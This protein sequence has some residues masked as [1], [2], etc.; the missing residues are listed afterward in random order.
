MTSLFLRLPSHLVFKWRFDHLAGAVG[1]RDCYLRDIVMPLVLENHDELPAPLRDAEAVTAPLIWQ[2]ISETCRRFPSKGQAGST[3]RI[4]ALIR[5][6][7]WTDAALAL[8]ELELPLWQVRRIAYDEGEWY[9][10]LSRERELPD[11]L[12]LAIESRHADLALAILGAFVEARHMAA[13]SRPSVPAASRGVNTL[14]E[15]ICCDNF[16]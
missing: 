8:I 7:A 1:D 4:E 11:W 3:A 16:G 5:S 6:E 14:Y 12:D 2:V 10:A 13:P 15:P 9:C